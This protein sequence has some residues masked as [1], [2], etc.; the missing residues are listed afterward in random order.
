MDSAIWVVRGSF[1]PVEVTALLLVVESFVFVVLLVAPVDWGIGELAAFEVT[2]ALLGVVSET[3]RAAVID[4]IVVEVSRRPGVLLLF[5]AERLS[6]ERLNNQTD[7]VYQ[8]R[9]HYPFLPVM[10]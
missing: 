10:V 4:V 9:F 2:S 6:A 7:K 5:E 1:D 3:V 8:N